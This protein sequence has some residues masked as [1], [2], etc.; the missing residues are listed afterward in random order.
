MQYHTDSPYS[1]PTY[2][3]NPYAWYEGWRATPPVYQTTLP[4]GAPVYVVTRYADVLAALKD[5]RLIKNVY[6]VRHQGWLAQRLWRRFSDSNMLKADPPTHT[7]LR[8][9][10]SDAFQPRRI[11]QMRPDIERIADGLID[12]MRDK[13]QC[14]FISDF[15]LPLPIHVISQMLGVPERDH[16]RFHAWSN[17]IIASG[18]LSSE[19]MVLT[20]EMVALSRYMRRLIAERRRRPGDDV[21][22]QLIAAEVNGERL[23]QT[24]LVVTT[25]L[26]LIAGHETTVN[27]LGN[28][29]LALLQH[30]DQWQLLC[31]DQARIPA[32]VEELLRLVNPVQ[33]V[34][35]YAAE[36]VVI[37]GVTIPRGAHVQLV[38]ASA[39][40][41]A[42]VFSSPDR[43][44]LTAETG[45]HLAFSQGIHYCLGAP[46][47]RLEGVVAFERLTQRMPTLQLVNPDQIEWRQ[48]LELRGLAQLLVRQL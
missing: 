42:S 21:V 24:E 35:R 18:V 13:P 10:A 11:A 46:L 22:S 1:H 15:A 38:I 47:A 14:D 41:D 44:D 31:A 19:R 40:H 45:R 7:R 20:R 6:N 17:A 36:E 3:A 8:R 12:R 23:S 26:L 5:P 39:N 9:L 48:G 33:L 43:L 32:A 34:N 29:L 2:R 30:P 4:S 16:G 27:L 28:G 25:I 37:A